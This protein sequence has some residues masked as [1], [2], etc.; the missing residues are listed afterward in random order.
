MGSHLPRSELNSLDYPRDRDQAVCSDGRT[1]RCD[2]CSSE[3]RASRLKSNQTTSGAFQLSRKR[4]LLAWR[5]RDPPPDRTNYRADELA[6][7][8]CSFAPRWSRSAS[9]VCESP[10][11]PGRCLEAYSEDRDSSRKRF[12]PSHL[13]DSS[14][15]TSRTDPLKKNLSKCLWEVLIDPCQIKTCS[16]SLTPWFRRTCLKS[17]PDMFGTPF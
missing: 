3:I 14:N 16:K 5:I 6:I 4:S 2:R 8:H 7:Q 11:Q 9:A 10:R 12:R 17:K 15:L 13:Q 1:A